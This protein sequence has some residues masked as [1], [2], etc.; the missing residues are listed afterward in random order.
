MTRI[1]HI[2]IG[3]MRNQPPGTFD[4]GGHDTGSGSRAIVVPKE[5]AQESFTADVVW[6]IVEPCRSCD[7]SSLASGDRERSVTETLMRTMLIEEVDVIAEDVVEVAEP[8]AHEVIE[9]F[10]LQR[11][12]PRFGKCVRVR[13][14]DWRFDDSRARIAEQLIEG[15]GELGVAVA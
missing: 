2:S 13:R 12:H 7:I 9:A 3:A 4:Q 11:A 5:S 14:P 10:S 6:A 1:D 15:C 8:E